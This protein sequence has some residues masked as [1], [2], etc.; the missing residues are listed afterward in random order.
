MKTYV[1]L[2]HLKSEWCPAA[3]TRTDDGHEWRKLNT[4]YGHHRQDIA[5]RTVT[6]KWK[7]ASLVVTQ[8]GHQDVRIV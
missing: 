3:V 6:I 7:E 4:P 5:K 1:I 8:V 2:Y